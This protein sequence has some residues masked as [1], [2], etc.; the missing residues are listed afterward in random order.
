M[1]LK[2]LERNYNDQMIGRL[3]SRVIFRIITVLFV[4]NDAVTRTSDNRNVFYSVIY[5]KNA[6]SVFCVRRY[7]FTM[8]YLGNKTSI[9]VL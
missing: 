3:D 2:Y 7:K 4:S 6:G 5:N 8:V 9:F 1:Y